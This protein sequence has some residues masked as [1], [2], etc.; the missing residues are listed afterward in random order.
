LKAGPKP[1]WMDEGVPYLHTAEQAAAG[2]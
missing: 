2:N 1:K